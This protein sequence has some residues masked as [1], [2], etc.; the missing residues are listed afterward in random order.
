MYRLITMRLRH[1][2]I[3]RVAAP[4]AAAVA[5]CVLGATAAQ[6]SSFKL[7]YDSL[8]S[9]TSAVTGGNF[10]LEAGLT[11]VESATPEV[12]T[13]TS[14][15]ESSA[16]ATNESGGGTSGTSG[17]GSRHRAAESTG[18]TGSVPSPQPQG[19]EPIRSTQHSPYPD[20]SSHLASQPSLQTTVQAIAI[21]PPSIVTLE[22][23][24]Q[25]AQ[26][27]RPAHGETLT[28]VPDVPAPTPVSATE[29]AVA[30]GSMSLTE[31]GILARLAWIARIKNLYGAIPAF[32]S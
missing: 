28:A 3:G 18:S 13:V 27:P 25:T 20:Q 23:A 17:G 11:A 30:L 29:N 14:S 16:Q 32:L 24:E 4:F 31:A 9:D 1:T 6:G 7:D 12:A 10:Q 8:Q 2:S 19:A 22:P 26:E 15:E 5:C 21:P